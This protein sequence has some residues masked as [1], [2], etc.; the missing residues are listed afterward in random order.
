GHQGPVETV[1]FSPD[2]QRLA[3]ASEDATARVWEAASGRLLITLEGHQD[4]VETVVFSPDGQRL[5]TA[6]ED[7]T[8][9]VWEAA[10]GRLFIT[11]EGHQDAVGTVAFS[12][13]GRRLAT[14]SGDKTA[15]V[16]DVS[17]ETR[18]SGNIAALVRC[19]GLWRLDEERLLPTNP[20]PTACPPPSPAP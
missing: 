1:V 5:A 20:D 9:R 12:P 4:A 19:K 15:R 3:T 18:S 14:A 16:W 7:A 6:S 10:S 2:G 11:L 17:L 13:D 8:A